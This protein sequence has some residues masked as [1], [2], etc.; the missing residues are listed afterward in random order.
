M[1]ADRR[2]ADF[3]SKLRRAREGKGLSLREIADAT[4]VSSRTLDALER[5]DIRYLTVR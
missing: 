3:G 2:T 5:K 4:R 1:S